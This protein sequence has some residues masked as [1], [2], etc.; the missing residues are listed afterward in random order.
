[1]S[2]PPVVIAGV[3]PQSAFSSVTLYAVVVLSIIAFT[4]SDHRQQNQ[5]RFILHITQIFLQIYY[6]KDFTEIFPKS[7]EGIKNKRYNVI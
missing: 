6:E 1:V 2:L 3:D 5:N 4:K 7:I